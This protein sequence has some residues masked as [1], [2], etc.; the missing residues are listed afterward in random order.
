VKGLNRK[1]VLVAVVWVLLWWRFIEAASPQDVPRP[2]R[3]VVAAIGEPMSVDPAW[4]YDTSSQELIFNVYETLIFYNRESVDEFVPVLAADW[5]ISDDGLTYTFGIRGGVKFHSGEMVTTEDVEYSFERA[6]VMDREGG[7]QWMIYESLLGCWRANLSDPD[8]D[9]KIDNTVESNATHVWF[10]LAQPYAPF[11]KILSQ[12]GSSILN[13]KFCVEHGDWPGT[14]ENW[15]DYHDPDVS[16]LDDPELAMCGT[17]PYKFDYWQEYTEW[18]IVKNDDYWRGW[19]APGCGGYVSRATV[20]KIDEWPTKYDGFLAGDYD[21]IYVPRQYVEQ[22]EEAPGIRCIKGL[23]TMVCNAI[24]FTF[25]IS[26]RDALESSNILLG[27]PGGLPPGTFNETGIPP[28]FFND[29]N[30]RKAFAYSCNWTKYI[31]EAYGGEAT[32]PATPVIEGIP[33]N[34]PAQEKYSL[35]LTM[36]EYYFRNAWDGQVWEKGFTLWAVYHEGSVP[37]FIWIDVLKENIESLNPRFHITKHGVDFHYLLSN[38]VYSAL[39]IVHMGWL[40]DYPDPHNFVYP[41]MHSEGDFARFQGY[42]NSTVD[43]L[44]E[45]GLHT[46]D[47]TERRE[48]YYQLQQIYHDECPS[49]PTVQ[50]LGRHWERTWVQGWYYN[51]AYPGNYFYHLWKQAGL[52]SDLNHDGIV[53]IADLFIIAKAFGSYPGHPRWNEIADIDNNGIVNINDLAT[54]AKEFGKTA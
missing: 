31:E 38:L 30:I 44:I 33:Y 48:I 39:P 15:R 26:T 1:F 13:K 29:T 43:A 21:M 14:W 10:D 11:L 6:M 23:P 2:D 7:P 42:S 12:P 47:A 24:L 3:M 52:H 17:G 28:D 22:L 18:S 19:P 40:A 4:A 36:A 25:N 8:W 46:V 5:W 51:P 16:P 20:K 9:V 27:V 37:R 34:N 45:D 32:Q 50:P 35:N 49:I 53:N 54:A 41:F